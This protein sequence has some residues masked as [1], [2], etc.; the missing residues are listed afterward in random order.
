MVV[1][2]QDKRPGVVGLH[3][4]TGNARQFFSP[5]TL[6]VELELDHLRIVCTLEPSFWEDRPVIHDLRLSSWLDAKRAGGKLASRTAKLSL[7]PCGPHAFR[8]Q[9]LESAPGESVSP[10]IGTVGLSLME[11][12]P[13]IPKPEIPPVVSVITDRRRRSRVGKLKSDDSP[14]ASAAH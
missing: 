1:L 10:E 11:A 3:I 7:I 2:T 14:S 13:E 8:L 12:Y 9:P 5:D 6:L 4:G